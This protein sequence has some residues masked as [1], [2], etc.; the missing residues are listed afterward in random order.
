MI[1][2]PVK[3]VI[4][5]DY[6]IIK[7]KKCD[8]SRQSVVIESCVGAVKLDEM[9]NGVRWFMFRTACGRKVEKQAMADGIVL[10][11]WPSEWAY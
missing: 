9:I 7:S 1:P 6:G 5:S 11:V 3:M 2:L 4:V 8:G 10:W